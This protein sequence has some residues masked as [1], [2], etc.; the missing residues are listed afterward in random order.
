MKKARKAAPG[1]RRG[2][3]VYF[4]RMAHCFLSVRPGTTLNVS[5]SCGMLNKIIS[6]RRSFPLKTTALQRVF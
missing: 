3:R 4:G 6:V 2:Q 1:L 5:K